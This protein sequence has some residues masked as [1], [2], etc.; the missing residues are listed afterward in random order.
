MVVLNSALYYQYHH[1]NINITI[2]RNCNNYDDD[3]DDIDDDDNDD[4][5]D[6]D[7]ADDDDDDDKDPRSLLDSFVYSA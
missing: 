7:A 6:D 5:D 4:D 3:E 1:S 2:S